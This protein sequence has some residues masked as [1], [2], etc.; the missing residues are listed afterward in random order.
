MGV[1]NAEIFTN[2]GLCCFYAQQFDLASVCLTKALDLADNTNQSDVWY[3]VGNVAL[4]SGDSEMAYQ[5]FTLALSSDQ[6]HAEACCNLAVLEMRKG[7][8]SA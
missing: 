5:C 2:L 7:N 1:Y 3:N 4:A 8:E 6:Q